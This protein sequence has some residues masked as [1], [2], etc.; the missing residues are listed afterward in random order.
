MIALHKANRISLTPE[1]KTRLGEL[2]GQAELPKKAVRPWLEQAT[3]CVRLDLDEQS[4]DW[5]VGC[6]Q[7]GGLPALPKDSSW[8]TCDEGA[9]AF[10]QQVNFSEI[11][12]FPGNPLPK[13]GLMSLFIEDD[14]E[15]LFHVFYHNVAAG[16]LEEKERPAGPMV[17]A[18]HNHHHLVAHRLLP[19]LAISLPTEGAEFESA[20]K[21]VG[22]FDLLHNLART[23]FT[24]AGPESHG[25]RLLGHRYWVHADH[26][27]R[28]CLLAH[29]KPELLNTYYFTREEIQKKL[30]EARHNHWQRE[31]QQLEVALESLAWLEQHPLDELR[32]PWL[33]L[34]CVESNFVVEACFWD[35]GAISMYITKEDLVAGDFSTPYVQLDSC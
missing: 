19:R 10:I 29:G 3:V 16:E 24:T 31:I 6:S 26:I 11:P 18:Y 25:G 7:Y 9:L 33:P 30:D 35:A 27:E 4:E 1:L 28:A 8:P 22:D 2:L 12:D 5:P 20:A 34:W 32:L 13:R 21:T 14:E 23:A 15:G 17:P